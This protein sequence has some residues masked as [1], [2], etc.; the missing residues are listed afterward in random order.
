MNREIYKQ[1]EFRWQLT[2]MED[3]EIGDV[4]SIHDDGKHMGIYRAIS[5]PYIDKDGIC[6]IR[7]SEM[8]M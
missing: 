4:I 2:E 1:T 7:I 3:V 5:S 8:G 6:T